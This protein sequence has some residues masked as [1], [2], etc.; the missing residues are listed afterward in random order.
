MAFK[1]LEQRFNENV[2][3]LYAGAT[4]KF[5]NG[6][7]STGRNDDPLIVRK[8]GNGYWNF[9]ESRGLP[10][11]S[12]ALDVKRLTLFTLSKRGLLFLAKQQLLQTGNTFEHTRIINP[13]FAVG[14]AV[15]F[16]HIRRNLRPLAIGGTVAKALSVLGIKKTSTPNSPAELRK[17]G[18]LQQ[19]TYDKWNGGSGLVKSLIKKIPVI[20]QTISAFS[21]KRS[22][23][24]VGNGWTYS[25]PELGK[26]NSE[27]FVYRYNADTA[28]GATNSKLLKSAIKFL[29]RVDIGGNDGV[30][31]GAIKSNGNYVTY[32]KYSNDKPAWERSIQTDYATYRL[33]KYKKAVLP[34]RSEV[35]IQSDI[36]EEYKTAS[37]YQKL[38]DSQ[39][40]DTS[41]LNYAGDKYKAADGF[42]FA[43]LSPNNVS[44]PTLN[45][46][47]SVIYGTGKISLRE[48]ETRENV[49]TDREAIDSQIETTAYLNYAGD[50]YNAADGFLFSSLSPTNVSSTT[51]GK[52]LFSKYEGI[53]EV[54]DEVAAKKT[55]ID[56]QIGEYVD[57]DVAL[58]DIERLN[59]RPTV[60]A[61]GLPILAEYSGKAFVRYFSHG[62]VG[63]GSVNA[64]EIIDGNTTNMQAKVDAFKTG[65]QKGKKLSYIKDESN[66]PAI[67][68]N[69]S[70]SKPAYQ[71]IN[72]AFDDPIV[73]SFAMGK[74][75]PIRFRAY[76]KDL[77]QSATPEYKSYQYI[78]RM[79]KF[80]NYVGVQREISFKLGVV[81]FSKDELN[82]VWRRINYLTGLVF[83][84]GFNRGIFQPNI[85]RLTI[86]NV[87]VEQPGYVTALSTNFNQFGESWEIDAGSQV[88]IAAEMDI[89]FIIIEKSSKVADS[90]FYGITEEMEGFSK[91]LPNAGPDTTATAAT[92]PSN[93]TPAKVNVETRTSKEIKNAVLPDNTRVTPRNPAPNNSSP[94]AR[95]QALDRVN[96]IFTSTTG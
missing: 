47:L 57:T 83:P 7:S 45:K 34:E 62:N 23:G 2:N 3:K 5:E 54:T 73:V 88:P 92:A 4:L 81:A 17:I 9:A 85:A 6:K 79:E 44:V 29:F 26:N 20:G 96:S 28:P 27:Y 65:P 90:P 39:I 74:D 78:G 15:P 95:Q 37:D 8:P 60:R 41:Y 12:A 72:N 30:G 55:D 10:V 13:L 91:Q 1:N 75:T 84:Y 94:Q 80:V 51:L 16:L 14:N 11:V 77:Q 63:L 22:M 86:G 19:E 38:L 48:G 53:A 25:R 33:A 68:P 50:K 32:L 52:N 46:D 18:Q 69:T 59:P 43:S 24:E 67:V 36:K 71:S 64:S 56:S 82:G 70:V 58:S 87:Y 35:A 42:L 49:N 21:A 89:K 93:D 76:I 66:L 40:K 31:Y 61:T